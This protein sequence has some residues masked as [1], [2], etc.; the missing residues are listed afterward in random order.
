ME[1]YGCQNY[2]SVTRKDLTFTFINTLDEPFFSHLVGHTSTNFSEIV[3]VGC[4]IENTMT[5]RKLQ[6][7]KKNPITRGT[8]YKKEPTVSVVNTFKLA[9]SK[10]AP[11]NPSP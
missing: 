3:M 6:V 2:N 8:R 5:T 4:R 9:K 1:G 10:L 7:D 11:A